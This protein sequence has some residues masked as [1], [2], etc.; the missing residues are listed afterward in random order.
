MPFV[1]NVLKG[2]AVVPLHNLSFA[3]EH[4]ESKWK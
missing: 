4:F 3:R 2:L 1:I